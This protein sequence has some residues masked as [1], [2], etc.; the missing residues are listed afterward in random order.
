MTREALSEAAVVRAA[1][2]IIRRKGTAALTMRELA[3]A[4]GVSPMAAYH[5]V[6]GK[7]DLLR[8]V[9]NHVW[10]SV[11]VP[12]PDSGPWYERLRTLV[13]AERDAIK[14]YRGLYEA[15]LYVDVE[16]KLV[17]EDAQLDLLLD[18]GCPPG[19][20]VPAFRA[21]RSWLGGNAFMESALRDPSRRRAPSR[22]S[23]AQRLTYD[24]AV[25]P[26]MHA[27]DYFA[28]GLDVVIAGLRV[29]LGAER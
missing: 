15:L 24:R 3:D 11:T 22:W 29:T 20:A 7:E 1:L 27:D 28:A 4:L 13:I 6:Q 17:L 21:L 14:R 10:G 5:H 9:G 2:A 25:M 16:Q 19:R 26:E 8:L 23:K 18:T 12:P